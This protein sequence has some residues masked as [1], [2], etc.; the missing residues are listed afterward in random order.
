MNRSTTKCSPRTTNENFQSLEFHGG[1]FSNHWK[2]A[3]LLLLALGAGV[4]HGTI[5]ASEDF[6]GG[7]SLWIDR[8]AGEMS[9]SHSAGFGNPAGSLHGAFGAQ[10]APAFESDAFR[11]GAASS[12]GAFSGNL[13]LS[14]TNVTNVR[15]AFYAEDVLPSTFIFRVGDGTNTFFR[16]I[17]PQVAAPA[18]WTT[19]DV[20]LAYSASWFGGT[21]AGFSNVFSGV[22]FMDVQIARNGTIAQDYFLDNFTLWGGAESLSMVPEPGTLS[23]LLM[24]AF[25]LHRAR[26]RRL[27]NKAG[28]RGII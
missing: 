9:V 20:S 12:G 22:S 21:A 11:V 2:R 18:T 4:A 17:T 1:I 26:K 3:A 5:V 16:N 23:L 13:Y 6:S 28:V 15:F 14:Y 8:D 19:V 27:K 24:G 7:S 10:G 25:M